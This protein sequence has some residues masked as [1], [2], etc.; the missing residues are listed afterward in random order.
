MAK[1]EPK[2]LLAFS[3]VILIS[4]WLISNWHLYH[5]KHVTKELSLVK[6]YKKM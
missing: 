5:Q 4:S 3:P 2:E 1:N 6:M